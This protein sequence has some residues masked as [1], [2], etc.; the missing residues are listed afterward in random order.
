MSEY[1]FNVININGCSAG[2]LTHI[3]LIK[4]VNCWRKETCS[5][6]PKSIMYHNLYIYLCPHTQPIS[7]FELEYQW[8]ASPAEFFAGSR[9]IQNP[10]LGKCKLFKMKKKKT[11]FQL[12]S[13]SM[14]EE[15]YEVEKAE[16]RIGGEFRRKEVRV[17]GRRMQSEWI[18][19]WNWSS[20]VPGLGQM[21]KE[22]D[23]R[24]K[25]RNIWRAGRRNWFCGWWTPRAPAETENN[26]VYL[27]RYSK[28]FLELWSQREEKDEKVVVWSH[29][30]T[31]NI[32]RSLLKR[33]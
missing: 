12:S 21:W 2:K 3:S 17:G 20:G 30:N 16:E 15:K 4:E 29:T 11:N 7:G 5:R 26:N 13:T 22:V 28:R 18:L 10:A 31:H 27:C 23:S 14:G 1:I 24:R 19:N 8:I 32:L 9:W 25:R 33:I 6:Y